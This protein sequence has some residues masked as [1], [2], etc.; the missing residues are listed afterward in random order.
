MKCDEAKIIT[1]PTKKFTRSKLVKFEHWSQEYL[2]NAP[3]A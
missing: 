3:K 2:S 1:M